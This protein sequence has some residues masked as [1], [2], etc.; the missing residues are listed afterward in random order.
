[1]REITTEKCPCGYVFKE[2]KEVVIRRVK[3]DSFISCIPGR[4]PQIVKSPDTKEEYSS[5]SCLEGDTKFI[6]LNFNKD[7]GP[8]GDQK[9]IACPKCGTVLLERI[10]R[11]TTR[12]K[13]KKEL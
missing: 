13:K 4:G 2:M 10:A 11:I 5:A 8:A 3:S 7:C 6:E 9:L 1:M 12:V